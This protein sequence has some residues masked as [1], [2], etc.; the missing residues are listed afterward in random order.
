[1]ALT[2]VFGRLLGQLH[3]DALHGLVLGQDIRRLIKDIQCVVE[4]FFR[5]AGQLAKQLVTQQRNDGAGVP[6]HAQVPFHRPLG[7]R[8]GQPFEHSARIDRTAVG[9]RIDVGG[10]AADVKGHQA[11]NARFVPGAPGKQGDGIQHS[12]RRG[13]DVPVHPLSQGMEA[14]GIYDALQKDTPHRLTGRLDVQLAELGHHIG[15]DDGLF[16]RGLDDLGRLACRALVARN[17]HGEGNGAVGQHL[18]IVQHGLAVAAVCAAGEHHDIR[19]QL[20]QLLLF[21]LRHFVGVSFQHFGTGAQG[22]QA[23]RFAGQVGHQAAGHHL[24][25]A[26]RAGASQHKVIFVFAALLFQQCERLVETDVHIGKNGG[27]RH[28]PAHNAAAL[29]VGA[30]HFGKGAADIGE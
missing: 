26:G 17:D 14:F 18:G 30:G 4:L 3:V 9:D 13:D 27:G 2:G 24:Q 29:Q 25:A 12:S 23:G 7:R 15:A 16:A 19:F 28:G 6:A 22:R 20:F 10:G 11:A 21:A 1:M 5:H 8:M